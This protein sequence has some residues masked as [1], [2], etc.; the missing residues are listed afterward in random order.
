M[1]RRAIFWSTVSIQGVH[2]A[3]TFAMSSLC[4]WRLIEL[5]Q[6]RYPMS[7]LHAWWLLLCLSSL[8]YTPGPPFLALPPQQE[9]LICVQLVLPHLNSALQFFTM[10]YEG[11]SSPNVPPISICICLGGKPFLCRYF[12]T[13]RSSTFSILTEFRGVSYFEST[14][15]KI[16]EKKYG[17]S[18]TCHNSKDR[19]LYLITFI[20]LPCLQVCWDT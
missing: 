19:S 5:N 10:D 15:W 12:I 8:L 16:C 1:S 14:L 2:R 20:I 13:T 17:I 7:L 18:K 11:A 9:V 6:N 3:D 4:M